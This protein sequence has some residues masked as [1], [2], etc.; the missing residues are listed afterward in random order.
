MEKDIKNEELEA[1]AEEDM[2]ESIVVLTDDEGNES[3]FIE[4]MVI[5]VGDK[6]FAILVG[7]SADCC[8]DEECHCHHD[9]DH[10]E[11]D[12][13]V[14]IARIDFDEDGEPVYVGPTDEEF[15]AVKVAYEKYW[16]EEE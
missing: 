5:P 14:V 13:N 4:E 10:E 6:N 11:E 8:E 15:E 16:E 12:E 3:Y 7:I 9:H 2:E 1:M